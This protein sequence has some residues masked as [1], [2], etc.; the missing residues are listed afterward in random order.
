MDISTL[1]YV[2]PTKAPHTKYTNG[3]VKS[4]AGEIPITPTLLSFDDKLG[5]IKVRWSINR[6]NYKVNPGLYAVGNPDE[7]SDVF[8]TANYK[9]SFDHLR[10]NLDS[11]N[12]WILVLDTNGINVWCAA[13]KGTFGTG[14]LINRVNQVNLHKIV[15]H[16]RLIVPQLGAVGVAAHKV[17]KA[18]G[19]NV[20]Y[21]PVRASDIKPFIDLNYKAT[22]EMRR[23]RFTF[24]D[25]LILLPVDFVFGFKKFLLIA[26]AIILVVSG[27]NNQG[28]L[29]H[30]IAENGFRETLLIFLA[31]FS[32]IVLTPMLLPIIP[33]RS[34][35]LKGFVMG[36]FVSGLLLYLN[37]LGDNYAEMLS[38]AF[39]I[40]S[41][42]S[43][44]ALNFTGAS[45]YTSLS[46]VKKEM[47]IALPLHS[48]FAATGLII[49]I[50]SKIV[51]P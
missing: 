48:V 37:A 17:K 25:R 21:G 35:A 20:K 45:T 29:F 5:A 40:I 6:N 38:W 47:K 46:G 9:L 7:K 43:F 2:T 12:A 31:F 33:F 15:D 4:K 1:E 23:V 41:I 26:L 22:D 49:L 18:T 30:E 50:V 44:L 3:F 10:K 34:F 13:G 24:I 39:I 16:K 11:I 32:G 28:I 14:E 19:F 27:L 36:I 51:N 8:V 42:S